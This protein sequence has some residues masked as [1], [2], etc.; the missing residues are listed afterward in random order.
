MSRFYDEMYEVA[1][2]L[3]SKPEEGFG[4]TGTLTAL[5]GTTTYDIRI[6]YLKPDRK[7]DFMPLSGSMITDSNQ[8]RAYFQFVIRDVF[9]PERG[10]RI[11]SNGK[12]MTIHSFKPI[13]PA[14]ETVVYECLLE[15]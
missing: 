8:R 4:T 15:V 6:A 3:L 9:V 11:T 10:C 5:D 14:D 12:T 7:R 2:E 1:K 13:S